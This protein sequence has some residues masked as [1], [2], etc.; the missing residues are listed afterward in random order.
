MLVRH[1]DPDAAKVHTVVISAAGTHS[2]I[3]RR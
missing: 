2:E 3:D 1:H